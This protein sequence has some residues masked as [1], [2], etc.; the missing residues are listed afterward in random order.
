MWLRRLLRLAW[1]GSMFSGGDLNFFRR[2][3]F[4][5]KSTFLVFSATGLLLLTGCASRPAPA[6]VVI[7]TPTLV[8]ASCGEC[9]FGMKG[10]DCDLAIRWKGK[11]YF[12]DGV[13]QDS[14]GDAHGA[15]G[16]CKTIRKAR[17]TGQVRDG[18]FVATSF[19][20]LPCRAP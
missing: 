17:V 15:E 2:P 8:E 3:D 1:M 5:M 7:A 6:P 18:R 4:S 13:N 12:V 16:I 9:K 10:D 14:L 20:L 11:A 19:E